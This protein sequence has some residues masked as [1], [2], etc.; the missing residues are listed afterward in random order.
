M[1]AAHET[2]AI[3]VSERGVLLLVSLTSENRSHGACM[4]SRNI[5]RSR[6]D[7]ERK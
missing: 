3:T 6:L 7:F 1:F 5:P 4:N 2:T